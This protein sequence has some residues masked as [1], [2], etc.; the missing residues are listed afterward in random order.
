M[1]S[2]VLGEL[3]KQLTAS[4]LENPAPKYSKSI[5]IWIDAALHKMDAPLQD[6][7]ILWRY[8]PLLT[9]VIGR[10]KFISVGDWHFFTY[11]E[12]SP[13]L[14]GRATPEQR[15]QVVYHEVAHAVDNFNGTYNPC[16]A[17]GKTWKSLMTK[18]GVPPTL[19]YEVG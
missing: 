10:A 5:C 7:K 12:F 2:S 14:F 15:R 4:K 18:A 11:L 17:H 1:L 13:T 19:H 3:Q 16:R 9:S 8:N 6:S